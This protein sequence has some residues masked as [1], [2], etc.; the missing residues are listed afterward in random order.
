MAHGAA[1][2]LMLLFFGD[3]TDVFI[4]QAVTVFYIDLVNMTG[5]DC[6]STFLFNETLTTITEL[7]QLNSP[8]GTCLLEDEFIREI[9]T[10]T[11]AFVGIGVSVFILAYIQISFVQAAA[12]R[13]VYKIRLEYYRAVLRQNI[14][15]FDDN[16]TGEVATRLSE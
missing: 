6:N 8:Q 10:Q 3:L 7:I 1:L 14:A 15:W 11:Y 9:N 16:P 2:P 5:I 12:E 13:Q 4:N